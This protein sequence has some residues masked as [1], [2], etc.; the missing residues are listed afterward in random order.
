MWKANTV[1]L[2][3]KPA[4]VAGL[5]YICTVHGCIV[6][7]LFYCVCFSLGSGMVSAGVW[8]CSV[9]LSVV[10]AA[11]SSQRLHN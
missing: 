4:I 3:G 7:H 11:L 1:K 10:T 8:Q 2:C 9:A 6:A 5:E